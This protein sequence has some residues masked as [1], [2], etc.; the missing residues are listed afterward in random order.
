MKRVLFVLILSVI[1]GAVVASAGQPTSFAAVIEKYELVRLALLNDSTEAVAANG[2]AIA[3]QLRT[4][5]ADFSAE[6]AGVPEDA[7]SSVRDGLPGMIAA[8]DALAGGP[9][10]ADAR[11]AFYDLSKGLVRWREGV[12]ST[13]P[14]VAY[15]PMVK[16]SWLQPDGTI[17]NPYGGQH[18]PN[19]G[20]IVSK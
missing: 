1:A 12:Q 10:L 19:C 3:K 14:V 9:G 7:A 20:R 15:C 6:K 13:R 18:M 17:G 16:K 2:K 11:N 5:Q 4:L 8:A